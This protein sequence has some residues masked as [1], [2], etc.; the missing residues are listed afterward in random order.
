MLLSDWVS[1]KNVVP[2]SVCVCR[3]LCCGEC[4]RPLCSPSVPP[5]ADPRVNVQTLSTVD[6]CAQRLVS[7]LL[8][9]RDVD[10]DLAAAHVSA[11]KVG[12]SSLCAL[13]RCVGDEAKA[14]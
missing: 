3:Q 11:I 2:V 5:L 9:L 12:D 7:G 8:R 4:P 6:P 10:T 13:A 1:V 14:S